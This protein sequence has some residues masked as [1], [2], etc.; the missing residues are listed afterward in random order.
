M[1][2]SMSAFEWSLLAVLS[3]LWGASF[4]FIGIAVTGLPTLTLVALR[5]TIAAA[6]LVGVGR[7]AGRRLPAEGRVWASFAMMG[8][9]N[10]VLPFCLIAWAQTRIFAGTA[11]VLNAST[12]L[13]TVIFA[14]FLTENERATRNKVLGVLVGFAGVAVL[15][16]PDALNGLGSDLLPELAVLGAT[17]FYAISSIYGRRFSRIGVSAD[18]AAAGQ[19]TA[20]AAILVPLALA[21]DQPF[22]LPPPAW[23][24]WLAV[25]GLAVF[26]TALAYLI[27]YRILATAGATNLTLVTLLIPASAMIMG[28]VVLEE[29][30]SAAQLLGLALIGLGLLAI[31]GRVWTALRRRIGT[32]ARRV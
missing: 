31:D 15:I 25:I 8:L 20:S 18:R 26:S 17:A 24:V 10:S 19:L 29:T 27:F 28:A 13:L 21:F 2:R 23:S 22:S 12:P 14:H 3:V 7:L 32:T 5:V 9:L 4:L 30:V 11:S 6:V 1:Q 16:G